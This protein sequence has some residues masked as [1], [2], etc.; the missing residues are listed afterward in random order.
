M[1]STASATN[2]LGLPSC[3]LLL[4]GF[5]LCHTDR[6]GLGKLPD[7]LLVYSPDP[8][9]NDI[10]MVQSTQHTAHRQDLHALIV[11]ALDLACD[12]ALSL[13]Y[14]ISD[15]FGVVDSKALAQPTSECMC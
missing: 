1:G 15:V 5:E 2:S 3:D 12:V 9:L 6:T 14:L 13:L 8:I 10:E 11:D 7:Y 4:G